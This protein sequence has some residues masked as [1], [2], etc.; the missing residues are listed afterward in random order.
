M[1]ARSTELLAEWWKSG[2]I[3]DPLLELV[4][5]E[6]AKDIA[7]MRSEISKGNLNA[8]AIMEGRVRML[9]DLLPVIKS[10]AD[11]WKVDRSG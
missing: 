6:S 8:A 3:T 7:I 5:E 1:T 10:Y 4:A 11:R 2:L 9:E